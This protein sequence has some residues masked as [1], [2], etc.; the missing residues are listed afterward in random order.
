MK[1]QTMAK[2]AM[3]AFVEI[4]ELVEVG[5]DLYTK[6]R[7]SG[8]EKMLELEKDMID[9]QDKI[10]DKGYHLSDFSYKNVGRCQHS[11]KL[12]VLDL[13]GIVGRGGGRETLKPILRKLAEG[14]K[15][16]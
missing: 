3:V 2:F 10:W 6:A 5:T 12:K 16:H 8:T 13:G 9:L 14:M 4:Q 7:A 1:L 11:G 15:P